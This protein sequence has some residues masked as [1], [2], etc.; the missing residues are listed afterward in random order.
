MVVTTRGVVT[1]GVDVTD[2]TTPLMPVD[3]IDTRVPLGETTTEVVDTVDV[4]VLS[5][6]AATNETIAPHVHIQH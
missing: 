5:A 4:V 6:D 1:E 3:T 2:V